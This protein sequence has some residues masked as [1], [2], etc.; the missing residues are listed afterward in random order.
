MTMDRFIEIVERAYALAL[1]A[2]S[3]E[4]EPEL[5]EEVAGECAELLAHIN[6]DNGAFGDDECKDQEL[7]ALAAL[8]TSK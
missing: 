3:G 5:A 7:V 6:Q 2:Q 1:Q 4:V 8:I